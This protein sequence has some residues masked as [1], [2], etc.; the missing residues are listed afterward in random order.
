[1]FPDANVVV[2]DDVYGSG[3]YPNL[4]WAAAATSTA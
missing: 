3:T 1:M 2:T 4:D